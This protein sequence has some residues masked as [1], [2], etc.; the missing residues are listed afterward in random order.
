MDFYFTLS[1]IHII[2]YAVI[3]LLRNTS[4]IPQLNKQRE[5]SAPIVK[6]TC[7]R[8]TTSE[9]SKRAFPDPDSD[10]FTFRELYQQE[11]DSLRNL[12]DTYV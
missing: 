1:V 5:K 11:K 8:Q 9:M 4:I 3:K 2:S 10:L 7:K 12:S 6:T